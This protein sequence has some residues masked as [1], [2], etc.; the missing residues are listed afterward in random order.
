M[1]IV[2]LFSSCKKESDN[3]PEEI[4]TS[5]SWTRTIIDKNTAT[6][7]S[8]RVMYNAVLDCELDDTYRFS[9]NNILTIEQGIDK[10]DSNEPA[11]RS[12][13]YAYDRESKTLSIDGTSYTLAEKS[14]NQIKYYAP[15][16]AV[17]GYDFMVFLL[18]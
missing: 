7:P 15:L 9:S 11:S 8:G 1:V 10:C 16:P 14:A 12:V 5:K 4:L 18:E 17:S 13:S 2:A 3:G 6:N